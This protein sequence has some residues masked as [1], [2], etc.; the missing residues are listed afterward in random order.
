M[1]QSARR[2]LQEIAHEL[3]EGLVLVRGILFQIHQLDG[4]IDVL[5]RRIGA[6]CG[7]NILLAQDRGVTLD[8]EARA[9]L[10]LMNFPFRQ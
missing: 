9:L 1:R 3:E 6:G 7:E 10:K 2:G 4:Q 5:G 8:E